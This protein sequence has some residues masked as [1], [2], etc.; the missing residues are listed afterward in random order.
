MNARTFLKSTALL[1][2]LF[3]I[4]TGCKNSAQRDGASSDSTLSATKEL[5]IEHSYIEVLDDANFEV[6][7]GRAIANGDERFVGVMGYALEIPG[8]PQFYEKYSKTHFVKVIKGT[9]DD[10]E[11]SSSMSRAVFYY[12]YAR[13]YN[14]LLLNHLFGSNE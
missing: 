1:I 8:V 10:Y 4:L 11:E 12:E 7:F 9:T 14:K 2:A 3:A 6:D 5:P 13:G